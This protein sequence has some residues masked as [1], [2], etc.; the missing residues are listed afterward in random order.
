MNP[1]DLSIYRALGGGGYYPQI[2]MAYDSSNR[3]EYIGIAERG[4]ATSGSKWRIWKNTY[5]GQLLTSETTSLP[6]QIWDNR[7]SLTYA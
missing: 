7:V 4:A 2:Q 5:T 6:D 1:A 3:L